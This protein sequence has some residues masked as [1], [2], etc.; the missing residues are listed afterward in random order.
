MCLLSTLLV[1]PIRVYYTYIY[2]QHNNLRILY[3]Y[4][5]TYIYAYMY[6]HAYTVV[7]ELHVSL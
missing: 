6:A 3:V 4:V 2:A 7:E 5:R 1:Y